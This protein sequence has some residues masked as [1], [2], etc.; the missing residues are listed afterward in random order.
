M[1][2]RYLITDKVYD[3][4]H[5][6]IFYDTTFPVTTSGAVYANPQGFTADAVD[7]LC[8]P[9][10]DLRLNAGAKTLTRD[11]DDIAQAGAY[12]RLRFRFAGSVPLEAV[13]VLSSEPFSVRAITLVDTRTG[14]FQQLA[15][16]PWERV[17][18]SDV[19][20]YENGDT[21]PRAFVVPAAHYVS[22][23]DAGT[24]AA[25]NFLRD[26]AFDAAQTVIISGQGNELAGEAA[27]EPKAGA[28]ITEYANTRVTL[29]VDA[30][31]P[32]YL[33]LTDAYYPGW[34]VTVN[35]EPALMLRADVMFRAV[36][37]PQGESTVVFEYRSFWL[38]LAPLA[39]GAAWLIALIAALA[40]R[41][42]CFGQN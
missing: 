14:S 26:P 24:E 39:G 3:L 18:S 21:L 38:P 23:D 17:V 19:K 35:G 20:I 22:D 41:R 7:V 36:Q 29:Q 27:D 1:G 37:V 28:L 10:G 12:T 9:C 15:P 2:V 42:S 8:N 30:P 31:A 4:N 11:N 25:L 40:L 34:T 32:G 5:E 6:G 33:V 16:A 13:E